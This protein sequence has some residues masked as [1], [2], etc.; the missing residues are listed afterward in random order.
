[1]INDRY[2][3]IEKIGESRSS[4]FLC[5]DKENFNQKIALKVFTNTTDTEDLASFRNEFLNLKNLEHPNIINAVEEGTVLESSYKNIIRGSKFF[6]LEYF[7]GKDLLSVPDYSEDDLTEI[8]VQISSVLFYLHQSNFIY[9]DLKPE[10]ILI[11][12]FNGKLQ[13]KLIDFGLARHVSMPA[14]NEIFG[15][16]EYIAPE[17][18]R[19]ELH[20]HRV[21][22]YSFGILLYRLIYNKFPFNLKTDIEIYK[23]HLEKVY[24]Y[25]RSVYS[26]GIINIVKKLLS[27]DPSDR[28]LNSIQI[29][30]EIDQSLIKTT[31]KNW[32]PGKIFID[33]TDALSI[34]SGYLADKSGSEILAVKGL[35]GAGKSFLLNKIYSEFD[36]AILINFNKSKSGLDF[37]KEFLLKV[38]FKESIFYSI[39]E[40]LKAK[41][42]EIIF[43][44]S[45]DILEQIKAVFSKISHDCN[46]FILFD[47]FNEIDDL[48]HDVL[49]NII[50]ILQVNNRKFILAENP[51]V[52]NRTDGI[53]GLRE[54]N[55]TAFTESDLNQF[56]EKSYFKEFPRNEIKNIILLY[57]DLLPGNIV[58]FIKDILLLGILDYQL[59]GIKVSTDAHANKLLQS[60]H[61]D[62]YDIRISSL[63]GDELSTAELISLFDISIDQVA[64]AILLDKSPPEMEIIVASLLQ[65]NIILPVHLRNSLNFTSEG[66]KNYIYNRVKDKKDLHFKTALN[67]KSGIKNFN[68]LE[69]ARQFELSEEYKESYRAIK[70]ELAAAEKI[71][72]YGYKKRILQ[73]YLSLPLGNEDRFEIKSDLVFVLYNL[74]E[75]GNAEILINELLDQEINVEKKDELLILKGSCLISSGNIE[76]GKNLLNQLINNIDDKTKL[77]KMLAEIATAEYE[78]NNFSESVN[79]CMK[80]I[81]DNMADGIQKGKCY[82]LLGLI[83]IFKE[84]NLGNA[85]NNFE[86]AINFYNNKKLN[87]KVAQLEKNIGNLYYLKGEPDRAEEYWNKSLDITLSIGNLELEA[88]LLMG[89]GVYYFDKLSLEKAHEFYSRALSIFVSLNNISG[90]GL[91]QHNIGEMC[92]LTGEFEKSIDAVENSIKIFENLKNLN[93]EME[94]LFLLGKLSF[95][96]G[97]VQKLNITIEAIKEKIK[98]EKAIDKHKLNYDLLKQFYSISNGNLDEAVKSC[99]TIKYRYLELEDKNNFF[100]VAV[101]MIEL[102]IRL[103]YYDEAASELGDKSFLALCFDNKLYN[104]QKNYLMAILSINKNSFGNPIDYLLEAFNYI[105]ESSITELSWKVLYRLSEIYFERGNYSKSEEYN[106]YA[107]SVLNYIINNIKDRKFKSII[108]ESSER[109]KVYQRLLIM[110]KNY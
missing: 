45:E 65:K 60:S 23:A 29:L 38:L 15:T 13:I 71:S 88:Q 53:A 74:S 82:N 94:S 28:Y 27:K 98:D 106:S 101:Q 57:A 42:K 87:Y 59:D 103:G 30:H 104:A 54:I 2:E 52:K 91:V 110:Q 44:P 26:S 63:S 22:L 19:K 62:I 18:L 50:P 7:P 102:L 40:D 47:N 80:I 77:F 72:A 100:F 69:L 48:T 41:F 32:A 61:E 11:A 16:A 20:D 4:V 95:I 5:S 35:E 78:L 14:G 25:P 24:E 3:I 93:E 49:K 86:L 46:F 96:I 105:K 73:K 1:M 8:I 99:R 17:L 90:Q 31:S 85:L 10:N 37:I 70:E 83:S 89:F 75:F 84:N 58:G 12:Y 97:D 107:M 108:M 64:A 66:L 39:S 21:D 6:T 56:L 76:S 92:L 34:I 33:R 43:N 109:G 68:R 51:G 9:Y 36:E 55:L 79:I 67:I 81:N